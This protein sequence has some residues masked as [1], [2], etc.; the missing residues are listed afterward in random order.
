MTKRD[1]AYL[2]SP[3]ILFIMLAVAAFLEF[4]LTHDYTRDDGHSQK[5]G[6]FVTNVQNGKWQ[7]TTDKW[8]EGMRHEEAT[9][10]SYRQFIVGT[11]RM[12]QI[13][14]W[15]AI[16]GFVFQIAIVLSIRKKLSK[17]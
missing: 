14:F 6:T 11:S 12:S 2:L 13:I 7:L 16:A 3:S 15:S 17:P 5:F 10:E 8:L 1:I 9:A 4:T